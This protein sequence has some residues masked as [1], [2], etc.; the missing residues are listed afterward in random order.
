M[1]TESVA[2]RI[3]ISDIRLHPL[4]SEILN[5]CGVTLDKSYFESL[6]NERQKVYLAAL[7]VSCP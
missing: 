4:R 5:E 1:S 6:S 3:K 7:E 2:D